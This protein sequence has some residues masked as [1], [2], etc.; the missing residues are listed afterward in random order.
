VFPLFGRLLTGV[1][2]IVAIDAVMLLLGAVT[3]GLLRMQ[4]WAWWGA[5]LTWGGV[6]LS[7]LLTASRTTLWE[8]L[9]AMD[10]PDRELEWFQEVPFRH[11]PVGL[12]VMVP[13]VMVLAGI[14]LAGRE[15]RARNF[16][17]PS[18]V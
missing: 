1:A 7:S 4:R 5:L 14:V 9:I 12:L 13:L 15:F 3:W 17:A 16:A 10:L 18:L 6:T 2:G 8:L 11:D